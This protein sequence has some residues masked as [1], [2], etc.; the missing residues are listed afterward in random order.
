MSLSALDSKRDQ[1]S[2]VALKRFSHFGVSKT[3]MSEIADDLNISKASLYY[4]FPDKTSLVISVGEI[5]FRDF[6]KEQKKALETVESFEEGF[7]KLLDVRLA[8]GQKF[9]MMH[10]G[11]GQSDINTSDP[12]FAEMLGELKATEHQLFSNYIE[13]FQKSGVIKE[14]DS[15]TTAQA[16]IDMLLGIW[17]CEVHIYHKSLI[18][19]PEIFEA[20]KNK[21]IRLITIFCDGIKRN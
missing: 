18:P 2:E 10:I 20:V 8:F 12:R 3:T 21:S 11:D 13:K 6:I 16:F 15:S 5:I 4:Y 19:M 17:V 14:L 9:F 1:I 7:L